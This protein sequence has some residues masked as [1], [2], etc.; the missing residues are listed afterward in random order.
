MTFDILDST[1]VTADGTALTP[2]T[3]NQ[4]LATITIPEN[5]SFK[6]I[7][8]NIDL[9]VAMVASPV[10]QQIDLELIND[11]TVVKTYNFS[12]GAVDVIG[13]QDYNISFPVAKNNSGVIVL[14]L[15]NAGS[16]DPD[17]S[18]KVKSI[19]CAGVS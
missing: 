15:G 13:I 4:T 6:Y 5:K 16:A 3:S 11:V 1:V 14:Q 12:P 9:E 2:T 19:W 10:V 17:I 8:V 7:L 18:F